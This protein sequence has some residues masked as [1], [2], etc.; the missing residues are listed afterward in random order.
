V[1][2]R[3]IIE[4]AGDDREVVFVVVG[5]VILAF[6]PLGDAPVVAGAHDRRPTGGAAA[7][8]PVI[9][10]SRRGAVVG[11]ADR[12]AGFVRATLGHVLHAVGT[13]VLRENQRGFVV[14]ADVIECTDVGD[15]PVVADVAADRAD[16]DAHA[17]I[18]IG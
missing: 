11:Q 12:V 15:A 9:F 6:A 4:I 1:I 18:F 17:V 8:T 10:L 13:E 14:I 16:Q 7:V 2:V 5:V 3:S